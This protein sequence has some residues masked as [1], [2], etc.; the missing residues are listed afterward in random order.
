LR[1]ETEWIEL[2]ENRYCLLT[3]PTSIDF[4]L[5][6]VDEILSKSYPTIQNLYC[7]G[8]TAEK[9]IEILLETN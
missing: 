3:P 7:E 5:S 8:N 6:N 1:D 4:I 2:V 9:I